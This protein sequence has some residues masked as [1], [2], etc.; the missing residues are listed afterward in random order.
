MELFFPPGLSAAWLT[1]PVISGEKQIDTHVG[2]INLPRMSSF[3]LLKS[4]AALKCSSGFSSDSEVVGSK[5]TSGET[6]NFVMLLLVF[7]QC[8]NLV[9][10]NVNF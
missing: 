5:L 1:A 2:G 8:M 10:V 4:Y 9:R 6:L 3:T 7:I